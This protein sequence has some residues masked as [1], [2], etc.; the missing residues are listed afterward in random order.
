MDGRTLDQNIYVEVVVLKDIHVVFINVIDHQ[1][2]YL[3]PK[4]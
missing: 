2:D 4:P 3:I 1:I